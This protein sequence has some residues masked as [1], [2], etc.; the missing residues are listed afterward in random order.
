MP[1]TPRIRKRAAAVLAGLLLGALTFGQLNVNA[2]CACGGGELEIVFIL[3]CSGSMNHTLAT[4]Q[5]QIKRFMEALEG[6]V[7]HMRAA[8]VIYRTKEYNGR[9]KKLDV[10]PFTGD[11]KAVADFLR[12]QTA[13][14]GGEEIIETA[15]TTALDD[16]KWTKGARKV[17]VLLGDEQGN[18][19]TQAKC[20]LQARAMREKGI[21]L[22]TVTASQTAWIYWAPANN[23]SWKQQ[24][25]G[26]GEEVKR[27]FKLPY[28]VD[29]AEAGGGIA[30]SSWSSKELVLWLLAFGLGMNGKD[31]KDKI[32]VDKYLEWAKQRDID[33]AAAEK[34]RQA[35]GPGAPLIAWVKHGGEWQVP[36]RAEML[37]AHIGGR[38]EL[39]G[40]PRM[41]T[42]A[43][44]D[45][46]LE[47][48]PVLYVSGHG[49]V[50]W[51]KAEREALKGRLERGGFLFADACCGDAEFT[52][53]VK[54]VLAEIFPGRTLEKLPPSHPIYACGHRVERVRRSE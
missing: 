17:A 12:S 10:L 5:E 54:E 39:A 32:D 24:L 41:Q 16:L 36:H 27:T 52:K 44:T 11:G 26:M 3:D 46:A 25:A 43:L 37:L 22:N 49:P 9:Q 28:Y 45:D 31:A 2:D 42:L 34:A 4:L 51:T 19:S 1:G 7:R 29:L 23:T 48:Y 30:V 13:E 6:Q 21:V 20:M 47:R 15:L 35:E 18:E 38:I 50:M 8:V 14:G 40:A 33:D 53:S